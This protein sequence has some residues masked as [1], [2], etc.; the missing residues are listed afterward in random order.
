MDRTASSP[1]DT[2]QK[3]TK[4]RVWL[5]VI[6]LFTL[7]V[8]Y[9]DRVNISV[10]M[11]DSQFLQELGLVNNPV[12]QGF[13]MTFFLIAYG[14]GN[15]LLSPVG[16][17]LGP[18]K[19]MSIA[20][21]SWTIPVMLGGMARSLPVLYVSRFILGAGEA[22]HY[23]M[24]I[25]FVKNWFPL[26]ERG[27]ANSVWV[28]GTMIGPAIAMPVFAYIV[29]MYGWRSTFWVCAALGLVILPIIWFCTTDR[30]GQ[31]KWVNKK[32]LEHIESGQQAESQRQEQG[33]KTGNVWQN[34]LLLVTNLDFVC[35]TVAYWSSVSMWWGIMSW[36]PQYLKVARGFSW[37]EMGFFSSLPYLLG[38]FG[39]MFAGYSAD[40]IKRSAPINCLG[41]AGCAFFILLG[42]TASDSYMSAIFLAISMFFK[43]VSQPMAWTVLQAFMPS[44]IIGQ[45]AGLQNGSSQLIG[46]LS[47]IV[48]G[49]LISVTGTYTAGL[50]YLVVFGF[51]GATSG[52]YLVYRKY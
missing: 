11:A 48:I 44:K 18:R 27:K 23:P 41:L 31:H 46:S 17:K 24:Q 33:V 13:L 6:L 4:I 45:A 14:L 29:A 8:A 35:S 38:I 5:V 10:I 26:Q 40:R 19:A 34:Y 30:P 9:L 15:V 47:P 25:K 43:G 28:M 32:E 49:Y 12:G 20:L 21:I 51:I 52:L 42:A 37:A 7:L 2:S 16:D 1:E 36:L 50:M 3:P 22:M 39:I